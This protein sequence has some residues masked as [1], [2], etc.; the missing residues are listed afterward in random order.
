MRAILFRALAVSRT[1]Q[2]GSAVCLTWVGSAMWTFIDWDWQM[3]A[4]LSAAMSITH[5]CLIS[6]TVLYRSWR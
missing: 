6:H 1:I 2:V 5:F 3:K 4:P